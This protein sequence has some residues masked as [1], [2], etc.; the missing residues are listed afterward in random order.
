VRPLTGGRLQ[1]TLSNGSSI[2]V[3]RD[4]R[5]VVLAQISSAGQR[6]A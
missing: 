5:R 3:A 6:R 2:I 1:L 4:R